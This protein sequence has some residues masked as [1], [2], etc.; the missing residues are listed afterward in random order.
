[1]EVET[2]RLKTQV[3]RVKARISR[4]ARTTTGLPVFGDVVG[5]RPADLWTVACPVGRW[6]K[7]RSGH[8]SLLMDS[9]GP[10]G[11]HPCRL[12]HLT[13]HLKR[14]LSTPVP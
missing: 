14:E 13:R 10:P 5:S 3:G 6:S 9:S 11:A 7:T 1:M 4:E 12:G 2:K 8:C